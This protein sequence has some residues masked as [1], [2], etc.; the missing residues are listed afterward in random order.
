VLAGEER[1]LGPQSYDM[2]VSLTNMALVHVGQKELD[3]AETLHRKVLR[4][5]AKLL[6]PDHSSTL[7]S[8]RNLAA[9]L[10]EK[11]DIAAAKEMDR[12]ANGSATERGS[13]NAG[14]LLM[15]GLL[16]D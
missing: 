4:M 9:V 11:G 5:R 12:R 15:A 1:L 8:A 14:A 13:D 2:Q 16:F 10:Y 7:F 3:E 6:G